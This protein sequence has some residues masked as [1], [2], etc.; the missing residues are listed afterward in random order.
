MDDIEVQV[1]EAEV[2][3][4]LVEGGLNILFAMST[5][6]QQHHLPIPDPCAL[7]RPA[8]EYLRRVPQ[9]AR[10]PNIAPGQARLIQPIC[11]TP[12]H[13]FLVAIGGCRIDVAIADLN[14]IGDGF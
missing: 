4:R 9:L 11:Y 8:P 3:E 7:T 13:L 12:A 14:R 2:S 6:R 1:V 5:I 10:N